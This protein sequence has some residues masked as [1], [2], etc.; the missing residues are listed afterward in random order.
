MDNIENNLILLNAWA[1]EFFNNIN[2]ADLN[3]VTFDGDCSFTFVKNEDATI[4]KNP[5]YGTIKPVETIYNDKSQYGDVLTRQLFRYSDLEKMVT[6]KSHFLFKL[7]LTLNESLATL[8]RHYVDYETRSITAELPGYCGIYFTDR[9]LNMAF[10]F[11]LYMKGNPTN[12][13]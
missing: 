5:I 2:L 1:D 13:R 10:E 9:P 6:S 11:R 3:P 8:K 7:I 12:P 4:L